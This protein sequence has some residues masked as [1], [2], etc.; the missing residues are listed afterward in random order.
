MPYALRDYL[1][2]FAG[3]IIVVL[4][5]DWLSPLDLSDNTMLTLF[6]SFLGIVVGLSVFGR[7]NM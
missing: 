2:L 4:A 3:G 1:Y 7:K 5:A 6:G